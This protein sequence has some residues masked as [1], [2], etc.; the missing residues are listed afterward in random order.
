MEAWRT[1]MEVGENEGEKECGCCM[2]KKPN[3]RGPIT[4]CHSIYK[5]AILPLRITKL[6]LLGL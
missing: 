5:N 1:K 6:S 3:S 4:P 2:E